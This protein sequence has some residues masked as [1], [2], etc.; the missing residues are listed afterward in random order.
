MFWLVSEG[1]QKL[2]DE[3]LKNYKAEEQALRVML[4]EEQEE[5]SKNEKKNK[6]KKLLQ[7]WEQFLFGKEPTAD[8]DMFPYFQLYTEANRNV[9]AFLQTR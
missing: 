3:R 1:L 9:E 2:W 4:E 5:R 6:K 7:V 8:N